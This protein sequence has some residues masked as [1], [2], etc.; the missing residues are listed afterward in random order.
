MSDAKNYFEFI[1]KVRQKVHS[2]AE[3]GWQIKNTLNYLYDI[4]KTLNCQVFLTEYALGLFFDFNKFG[5]VAFRA[6]LDALPIEEKTHLPFKSTNGN[7]HACG[8]DGHIAIAIGLAKFLSDKKTLVQDE[9]VKK[10]N[11]N[12][13][14]V[15][16]PAE[17]QTGGMD[18]LLSQ[19]F[20]K[21]IPIDCAFAI[22]LYPSLPKGKIY[23]KAKKLCIGSK[24]I[25]LVL[26]GKPSHL[27][28]L[29]KKGD[30]LSGGVEFLTKANKIYGKS[31]FV[32]FCKVGG[33]V[34]T[35]VVCDEF[36]ARGSIRFFD[37]HKMQK[38]CKGLVCLAN[39]VC[40]KYGLT[41]T[42]KIKRGVLPLV[43]N[44]NMVKKAKKITK[45]EVCPKQFICDDFSEWGKT[46]PI[47]Y[48][49]LGTGGKYPLHSPC[50]DFDSSLLIVALDF[51]IKFVGV[52]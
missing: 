17:E 8:H 9:W 39:R 30:A 1:N 14:I 21:Q 15:F 7:A 16:E 33:G 34:A 46:I 22:H 38:K 40:N 47:A 23:T 20:I 18:Y 5:C 11:K 25:D 19:E 43:C 28:S 35:N 37:N 41:N 45:I 27:A 10:L 2:Q 12:V 29:S 36:V 32:R 26:R 31:G 4:A 51:C 13:L 44:K 50:F 48:F 24:E 49:L 3:V 52:V 42:L 6:E